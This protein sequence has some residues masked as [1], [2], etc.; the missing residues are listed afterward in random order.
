MGQIWKNNWESN[1]LYIG[2]PRLC[3]E[4]FR[5]QC[6]HVVDHLALRN[7]GHNVL[8]FFG[9]TCRNWTGCSFFGP[10]FGPQNEAQVYK[11]KNTHTVHLTHSGSNVYIYIY[12]TICLLQHLTAFFLGV[13][14]AS[15]SNHPP[16][17]SFQESPWDQSVHLVEPQNRRICWKVGHLECASLFQL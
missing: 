14:H 6:K 1:R 5:E 11:R 2:P 10:P 8:A 12:A 16:S 7:G 17:S 4:V 9:K 15:D 3:T 13:S